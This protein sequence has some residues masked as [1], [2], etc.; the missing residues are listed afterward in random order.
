M[1]FLQSIIPMPFFQTKLLS[2]F[3]VAFAVLLTPVVSQ[4]QSQAKTLEEGWQYRWGDSPF[5]ADGIPKWTQDG[6][7]SGEWGAIDFPSNPPGRDGQKNVWYRMT[8]PEDNWRDPVLYVFSID[9]IAEVYVDGRRIYHYGT[10]DENGQG[11]FEGWPWHMINLPN[12]FSGKQIYFR[13]FSTYSDIGLWGEV[14]LMERLDLMDS[15]FKS[16]LENIVV[17]G[18]SLLIAFMALIFAIV[19]SNRQT[20]LLISLF[21]FAS[22]T[23][24]F[25]QSQIKQ[26]L[27]NAPLLWDHISATAYFILP[28]A[29]ALLFGS[30]FQGKFRTLISAIWKLHTLFVI[31]AIGG[32][33]IGVFELS[34]MYLVFDGLL[35]ISLIVLFLIAFSQ[36][37]TVKNEVKVVTGTFAVISL[38]LLADMGVAHNVLPW[39]RLPI[40]WGLLLFS[41]TMVVISLRHFAMVQNDLKDMNIT[42][43]QKVD[44]RTKE[45]SES[46]S[47]V[48]AM[49]SET[50][51][52]LH[53]IDSKGR[54]L[55]VSQYWLKCMGYE[56]HEV[57]GAPSVDFLTPESKQY[58]Q[59]VI[60]PTF[61]KTG[62]LE[63]IEYQFVR[64]DGSVFDT[65]LSATLECDEDGNPLRSLAVTI[66]ITERKNAEKSLL[67][68]KDE[69]ERS[70]MAK[71]HFLASASHD[72]RQPLQAINLFLHALGTKKHDSSSL[73][74]IS[75]IKGSVGS[76]DNLLNSLLDISRLEAEL[77]KPTNKAFPLFDLMER[78]TKEFSHLAK[79]K[80]MTFKLVQT[81]AIVCSDVNL[82][83]TILRNF[84]ANAI[85]NTQ[86]GKVLLGCRHQGD[87]VSL[88]VWDNGCGIPK[89]FLTKIFDE[90]YQVGN[91]GRDRNK[92]L[93]LGLSIVKKLAKLLDHQIRVRSW[94]NQGSV[95]SIELPLA[96]QERVEGSR[97]EPEPVKQ[98]T[99]ATVF[100]VD[101]E[102]AIRT[103]LTLVLEQ[104][105]YEVY[106]TSG[107]ECDKCKEM[108]A[109]MASPPELILAD[110]RLQHG[111]TG[112]DAIKCLRECFKADIPAI[113]VTGDTAPE[114]LTVAKNSGF[115]ILHKPIKVEALI[116]EIENVLQ[117]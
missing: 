17:S 8:L 40:A 73:D 37:K 83:E 50:P 20:Y 98:S 69:A 41:M 102:P 43:E 5:T 71:S 88:E 42:L 2:V 114:R 117:S 21:T 85:K 49:Y 32:S 54:L 87:H 29:M 3:L 92:G 113:L 104:E 110:F 52:M 13:V 19:Q 51:V 109:E 48:R 97:A 96:A 45:L 58:A 34:S 26:L 6:V 90:F 106:S 1:Y 28:I 101:D 47:L 12:D 105:G 23:M 16:S 11:K 108:A 35:T 38:F 56:E 31:G 89:T 14:K 94:E 115:P 80:G 103:S 82:L 111:N 76:L 36:F 27:F 99:K 95:F 116:K 100:I 53:S 59:E 68:A 15:V 77:V 33:V 25:S 9:L 75:N 70:N 62:Y 57:I 72:L 44:D 67:V 46:E 74:I 4:A 79:D 22:A 39:T 81:K 91:E 112:L 86:K 61:F 107:H 84:L 64:K 66:D 63:D 78:L 65:L 55:A 18:L 60:L 93:G 30:W 7:D 10:F 24:L